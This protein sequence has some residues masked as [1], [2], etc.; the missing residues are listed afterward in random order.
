MS[1]V[2]QLMELIHKARTL[3]PPDDY[4]HRACLE[5]ISGDADAAVEA[6]RVALENGEAPVDWARQ[7]PDFVFI[8]D[9]PR[10]R[11]LVGREV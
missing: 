11:A 5:S 10:Y 2:V 7:D 4:Y 8:R 6:L 3:I 9:D 1:D